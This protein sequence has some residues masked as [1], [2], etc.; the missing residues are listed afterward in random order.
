MCSVLR[1]EAQSPDDANIKYQGSKILYLD[2]CF[3]KIQLVYQI[4]SLKTCL[5]SRVA[6]THF[7]Y[8]NTHKTYT[9]SLLINIAEIE[10]IYSKKVNTW[11]S[12]QADHQS[13]LRKSPLL[14][15]APGTG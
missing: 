14:T 3:S 12:H 5:G 15:T 2:N 10:Y 7:V 13:D 1:G 8:T 9:N 11:S 4:M 6:Y